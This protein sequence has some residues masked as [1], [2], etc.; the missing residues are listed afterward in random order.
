MLFC[1]SFSACEKEDGDLNEAKS[2]EFFSMKPDNEHVQ[3]LYDHFKNIEEG[4][5]STNLNI[6]GTP[7][8]NKEVAYK[9]NG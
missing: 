2:D 5:E 7:Y 1:V 4:E 8:W 6:W 3:L 9:S